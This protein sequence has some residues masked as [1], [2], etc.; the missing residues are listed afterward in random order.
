MSST[1]HTQQV[2]TGRPLACSCCRRLVGLKKVKKPSAGLL[3]LVHLMNCERQHIPAFWA[4]AM[5]STCGHHTNL[6][7][8]LCQ[9]RMPGTAPHCPCPSSSAMSH[10][11]HYRPK[12]LARPCTVAAS[13]GRL[14]DAAS[15]S[16]YLTGGQ[17]GPERQR[18]FD[19]IAPV[20]DQ[21]CF[22]GSCCP[23]LKI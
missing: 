7:A 1:A 15:A 14:P 8:D 17:E 9:C 3:S 12:A 20:Y 2:Y 4:H 6:S 18:L 23:R 19:R 11:V 16:P 13:N 21:V 5:S 10:S 22:T